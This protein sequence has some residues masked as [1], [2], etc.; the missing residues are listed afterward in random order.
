MRAYRL[1]PETGHVLRRRERFRREVAAGRIVRAEVCEKCEQV[2]EKGRTWAHLPNIDDWSSVVWLCPPCYRAVNPR[3]KPR[4]YKRGDTQ[5]IAP[6]YETM[7]HDWCVRGLTLYQM[8]AEYGYK[9]PE[10]GK[11]A[12]WNTLKARAERRGEWPL[13]RLIKV[14]VTGIWLAITHYLYDYVDRSYVKIPRWIADRH[15]P[16]SVLQGG[17]RSLPYIGTERAHWKTIFP[18]VEAHYHVGK[19]KNAINREHHEGES[20]LALYRAARR[21]GV[22]RKGIDRTELVRRLRLADPPWFAMTRQEAEDWGYYE[23]QECVKGLS[24]ADFAAMNG[25]NVHFM[26]GIS[27]GRTRTITKERA[28]QLLTAIGEP[29]PR[30]WRPGPDVKDR[31]RVADSSRHAP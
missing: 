29:I 1:E 8:A 24:V 21:A 14:D 27:S 22:D 16:R 25:I 4:S 7:K 19:C 2:P 17:V 3:G 28:R 31:R 10:N 26:W 18:E 15:A 13:S 9:N 30:D 23:C 12:V 20:S 6:D 11:M 5:R